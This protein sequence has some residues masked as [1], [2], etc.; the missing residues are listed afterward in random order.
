M[1]NSEGGVFVTGTDTGVGKTVVTAALGRCLK[2]AGVDVGV[3]KPFQTGTALEALTDIEFVRK[4]LG[5][6]GLPDE[7]SPVRLP[8]PLAP[9]TAALLAGVDIDIDAVKK[10]FDS[11]RSRHEFIIVEGAGGLLVPIMKDYFMSDLA[12]DFG[13]PLIIVTRPDLG[14]IN[15]TLLT[16]Q[17]ARAGG[18]PVKGIVICNFP[19][20]PG[21]AELTNPGLISRYAGCPILGVLKT[22]ETLCVETGKTGSLKQSAHE[23]FAPEF[24]GTFSAE[25][26]LKALERQI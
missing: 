19:R 24:G 21:L 4:V 5:A 6:D 1:L 2:Q 11:L 13:L 20:E 8:E 22:D 3:M 25:E 26:F 18:L 9:L 12:R 17:S 16:V 7:A 23:S 10:T 14:T 15:H